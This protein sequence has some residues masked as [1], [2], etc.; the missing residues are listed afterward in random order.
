MIKPVEDHAVVLFP[1]GSTEVISLDE[2]S[3]MVV[4]K[5]MLKDIEDGLNSY[6]SI[7]LK[8][9][10]SGMP[11]LDVEREDGTHF[12]VVKKADGVKILEEGEQP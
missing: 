4:G 5:T 6:R 2:Y 7:N 11:Y 3:L 8:K 10:P 12:C 9:H 1:D